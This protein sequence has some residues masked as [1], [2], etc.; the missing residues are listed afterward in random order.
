[1]RKNEIWAYESSSITDMQCEETREEIV[2]H[3]K[4]ES[5]SI[6]TSESFWHENL[7]QCALYQEQCIDF[8]KEIH[9]QDLENLFTAE[10]FRLNRLQRRRHACGI[11]IIDS[12]TNIVLHISTFEWHDLFR[13]DIHSIITGICNHN[14]LNVD[15]YFYRL[16]VVFYME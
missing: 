5:T 13:I 9:I 12:T 6:W 14:D 7:D 11:L 3:P 2:K 15:D 16:C 8:C 10:E 4:H 1:M